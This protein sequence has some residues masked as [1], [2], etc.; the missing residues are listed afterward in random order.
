[1]TSVAEM[2]ARVDAVLGEFITWDGH[3]DDAANSAA[4]DLDYTAPCFV[5]GWDQDYSDD[6]EHDYWAAENSHAEPHEYVPGPQETGEVVVSLMGAY[7]LHGVTRCPGTA[8]GDPD[9]PIWG[10]YKHFLRTQDDDDGFLDLIADD[11]TV[12]EAVDLAAKLGHGW[13]V[14]V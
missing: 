13:P 4:D 5:C 1:M 11:L 10:L 3:S 14:G 12:Q 9:E 7:E 6:L 8:S 2:L